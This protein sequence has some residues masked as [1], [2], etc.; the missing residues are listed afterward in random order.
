VEKMEKTIKKMGQNSKEMEKMN[1]MLD[2][3]IKDKKREIDNINTLKLEYKNK[4]REFDFLN[5]DKTLNK[6]LERINKY[7]NENNTEKI[8]ETKV[9]IEKRI[10][11]VK[12]Y[13]NEYIKGIG[14]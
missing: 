11:K 2:N 3:E 10:E 5:E 9:V 14:R 8:E 4:L 12:K 6:Y 7:I 13:N 1:I